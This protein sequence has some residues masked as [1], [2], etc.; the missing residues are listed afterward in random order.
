MATKSQPKNKVAP[1][2]L[3][4]YDKL[5]ETIPGLQ[6]KG[7]TVPNTTVNG[8]MFSYLHATEGMA[9][10]LPA[11]QLEKFLAQYKT[12]LFAA[13][14]VVQREYA[15]VPE[16]LLRKTKELQPFFEVSYQYAKSL[17]VKPSKRK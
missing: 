9:I 3:A 16:D 17:K 4:L 10:R 12:K 1:E 6:R 14:G 11:D 15:A 5:I 7:A 13:Y 8:N 2:N